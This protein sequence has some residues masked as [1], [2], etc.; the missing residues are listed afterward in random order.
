MKPDTRIEPALKRSLSLPL[1]TFYGLGNIL[2]AGIYVLIGKVAGHAGIYAPIAFLL[3]SLLACLTAFTYAELVARYPVS[4]GEAVYLHKG[5][6][7]RW[8][9]VL[10]GL[11]IILAG[12]VSSATLTRGFV[13]YLQVFIDV[14]PALIMLLLVTLLGGLAA[15]G[16]SQSIRVAATFTVLEILGLLLIIWVLRPD[17]NLAFEQL[18]HTLP[19]ANTAIWQGILMGS[20]LAF[21]AFIG[22]EDMVNVAEEVQDPWRNL[23]LAILAALFISSLLYFAVAFVAVA[24]FT[25][26]ELA[27]SE[28]PL[29]YMYQQATGKTPTVISLIGMV[30][31]INGALIQ[32]IMAARVFYGLARQGWIS[33]TLGI[34]HPRTQT[35]LLATG[36]VSVLVLVMALWLPIETLAK[37]TSYFILTVFALVNLALWRIKLKRRDEPAPFAIPLWVPMA[38]FILTTAFLLYQLL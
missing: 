22:F 27:T 6:A 25:P 2:G 33:Q 26:D 24:K 36:L 4:A 28:A 30:A 23:P 12:V 31:V 5:F 34:I 10:V 15:W 20:F 1:I 9:S 35:P 13:G 21:Y 38:G 7:K 14:P 18:S 17:I 8:L 32:I 11:L 16:I 37:V 29:A 3:A 19:P